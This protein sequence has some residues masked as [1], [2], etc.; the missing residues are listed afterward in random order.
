MYVHILNLNPPLLALPPISMA[1]GAARLLSDG[2]KVEFTPSSNVVVL[3]LPAAP[4][5]EGDRVVVPT[6]AKDR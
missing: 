2:S 5:C 3:K 4:K 1:I 6:L